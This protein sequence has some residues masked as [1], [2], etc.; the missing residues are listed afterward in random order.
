MG[1]P[2]FALTK[3]SYQTIEVVNFDAPIRQGNAES[4]AYLCT[5]DIRIC[6]D[7]APME[8]FVRTLPVLLGVGEA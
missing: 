3:N 7:A 1:F 5:V 2:S 4:Q 6:A 8:W